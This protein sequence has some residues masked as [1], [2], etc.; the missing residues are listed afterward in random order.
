MDRS[1]AHLA[2]V[3]TRLNRA[4]MHVLRRAFLSSLVMDVVV[5]FAIAVCASYVGLV[6]LGYV[7]LPFA[8]PLPCGS[9]RR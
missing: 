4:T 3:S 9:L 5:T 8:P 7:H 6:L 1:R 2:A